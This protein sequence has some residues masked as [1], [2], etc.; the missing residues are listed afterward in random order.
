MIYV[1]LST[2]ISVLG[3]PKL[4]KGFENSPLRTKLNRV[5]LVGFVRKGICRNPFLL[6]RQP[7]EKKV[8]Q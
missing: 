4:K 1:E 6:I 7:A 3:S 8:L 2:D 5:R